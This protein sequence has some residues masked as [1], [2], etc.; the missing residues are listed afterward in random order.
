MDAFN[1]VD[2][3]GRPPWKIIAMISGAVVLA[4]LLALAAV[5]FV[6][7]RQGAGIAA[8]N[9][10]RVETKL[11][12]ELRGCA[13]E[14]FPDA[15]R[16]RKVLL[17]ASATGA[18]S[19][20]A[21]LDGEA[22]DNCLLSVA[23]DRLDPDACALM[24]DAALAARC[25]DSTYGQIALAARDPAVCQS[26]VDETRRAGCVA[27]LSPRVTS[28]NCAESGHDAAYCADLAAMDA[29]IQKSDLSACAQ[30]VTE[31]FRAECFDAVGIPD[32]DGDGLDAAQE[33]DLG[34]S[35]ASTDSDADGLTDAEEVETYR[36]NP[37]KPDT[38]GDGFTDGDE[39]ANGYNPA[40]P[41]KL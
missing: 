20:C 31:A 13:Q 24:E 37:T 16:E 9:L 5:W 11:E 29:A 40:G 41:G 23:R 17:A 15:C 2:E 30:I 25:K 1:S 35:D 14:P 10:A 8:E 18:A 28:K 19:V 36:S 34:T 27:T 4:V 7:S 3:P 38:D 22:H 39:V 33:T 6:R 12:E 21:N 32:A 26:I